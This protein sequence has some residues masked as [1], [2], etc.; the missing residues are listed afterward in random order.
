MGKSGLLLSLLSPQWPH[1][2]KSWRQCIPSI[3]HW[4]RQPTVETGRSCQIGTVPDSCA[5]DPV[6]GSWLSQTKDLDDWY[7]SFPSLVL[8]INTIGKV[9]ISSASEKCDWVGYQVIVPWPD[10]P[11]GQHY[12][13]LMSVHCS[14][15]IPTLIRPYMLPGCKTLTTKPNQMW[16]QWM[17][18]IGRY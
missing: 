6:F 7:L 4:D 10:F 16:N 17:T 1:F 2:Q 9:L 14:K 18:Q 13:I 5:G 11:V 3:Q 15:L 8:N 12:T